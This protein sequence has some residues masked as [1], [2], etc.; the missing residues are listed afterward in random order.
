MTVVGNSFPLQLP[1][2]SIG[3]STAAAGGGVP[4]EEEKGALMW[5]VFPNLLD[6]ETLEL[7][8]AC[9]WNV[10]LGGVFPILTHTCC[11]WITAG[12]IVF[13]NIHKQ[14]SI[15]FPFYLKNWNLQCR[16]FKRPIEHGHPIIL[17]CISSV[18]PL[19]PAPSGTTSVLAV[20][21]Y[22]HEH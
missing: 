2:V 15:I 14:E 8:G 17:G 1:R 20:T 5:Q 6:S 21:G 12:R 18:L 11:D 7:G 9:S 19:S 13:M 16:A 4:K 22:R 3:G 10:I